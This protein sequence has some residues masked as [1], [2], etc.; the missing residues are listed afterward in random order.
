MTWT[1]KLKHE[2]RVAVIRHCKI[3]FI[4]DHGSH[5]RE[6][7]R[8]AGGPDRDPAVSRQGGRVQGAAR[9]QRLRR[10][11]GEQGSGG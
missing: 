11:R 7:R 9:G 3:Q 8:L 6:G 10:P 4:L 2:E 1:R 5:V